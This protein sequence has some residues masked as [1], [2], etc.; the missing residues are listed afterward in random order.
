MRN[1]FAPTVA[2][3]VILVVAAGA[4]SAET[5]GYVNSDQLRAE[6][7]GAR[8][9]N[10]QFEA[11]L[12]D[13]RSQARDKQSEIEKLMAD[14]QSQRLLLSDEAAAE[15]E[16][17]IQ[18]KQA[19]FETYLNEVWGQGGLVEQREAELWQPVY[20][21]MQTIIDEIGA[22]GEYQM[23]FDAARMGIVYA[24]PGADITPQ[25][26]ERLNEAEE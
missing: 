16:N 23:I 13:W 17:A 21:R 10:S 12:A 14:L 20:D 7:V 3:A 2:A 11:S 26:L 9:I 15:K 25:V 1:A 24:D 5:I 19:E 4:W 22:E 6:Y 8:D 18:Q